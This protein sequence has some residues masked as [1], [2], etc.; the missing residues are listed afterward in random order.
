MSVGYHLTAYNGRDDK[1]FR[2]GIM[3]SGGSIAASPGNYTT[4]QSKYNS[5]A[6]K[7]GCSD[8]VDSLQCLREVPFETLN[9]ALNGTEGDSEYNFSPVVDGD[10]IR[11]WGSIQLSKHAF[12]KVPIMAGTNTD[13][14]TAFGPT[15]INTTEQWYQYLTGTYTNRLPTNSAANPFR[16]R[17]ELS[18]TSLCSQAHPRTLPGRPIARYSSVSRRPARAFKWPAMAPHL[19]LRRR[20]LHACQSPA[21]MRSMGRDINP[22]ILLPVQRALGR[23]A[24]PFGCDSFRGGSICV[25]QHCRTGISLRQTV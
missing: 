12:V 10:L 7:V 15:G 6:S 4:F 2:A 22:S 19:S 11:N 8:V 14:G 9:T 23:C 1:L 20:S 5:L 13:E 21:T 18:N 16:W 25:P 17:I 24:T 3:Q